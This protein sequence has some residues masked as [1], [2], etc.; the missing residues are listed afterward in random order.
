VAAGHR[1][2]Q[3]GGSSHTA[4][5]EGSVRDCPR[6]PYAAFRN[7]SPATPLH[8]TPPVPVAVRLMTELSAD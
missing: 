8:R 6:G 1:V 3:Y 5:F 4:R 7:R 2:R